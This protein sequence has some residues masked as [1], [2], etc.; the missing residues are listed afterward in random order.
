MCGN[1]LEPAT[2]VF[3]DSPLDTMSKRLRFQMLKFCSLVRFN[4]SRCEG[5]ITSGI[6]GEA[7]GKLGP[8]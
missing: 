3:V 1:V 2:A 5:L 4:K 8:L 6:I 7:G